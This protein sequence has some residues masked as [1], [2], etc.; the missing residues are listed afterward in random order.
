MRSFITCSPRREDLFKLAP[1][2]FTDME[3]QS[4]CSLQIIPRCYKYKNVFLYYDNAGGSYSHYDVL[5]S[6]L[7]L[8][9]AQPCRYGAAY[10]KQANYAQQ[11][12]VRLGVT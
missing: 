2:L 1:Y 11:F 12:P 5:L 7:R 3:L 4:K 9:S 6:L 8:G 10:R